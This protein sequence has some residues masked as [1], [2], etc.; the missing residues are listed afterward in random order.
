MNRAEFD[1]FSEEYKFLHR[2]NIACSGEYPEY[3]AEYKI[4]DLNR[5][6]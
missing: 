4:K 5:I 3:F 6:V 1:E 2:E